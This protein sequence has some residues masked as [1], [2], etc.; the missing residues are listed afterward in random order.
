MADVLVQTRIPANAAKWLTRRAALDGDTVAGW[1]RRLITREA[2]MAHVKAWI[3]PVTH[4]DPAVLLYQDRVSDYW[5]ELLRELTPTASV[6]AVGFGEGTDRPGTTIRS[7]AFFHD[8]HWFTRTDTYR[9]VLGGSGAQRW[10]I[11]KSLFNE[12]ARRLEL[13]L[14]VDRSYRS[15][16]A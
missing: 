14:E 2:S 6:F 11:A 3:E 13:T 16:A 8:K 12:S 4:S 15:S 7:E 1:L 9:V 10:L 5:F